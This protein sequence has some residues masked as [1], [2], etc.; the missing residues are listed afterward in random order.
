MVTRPPAGLADRVFDAAVV[1]ILALIGLAAL[2]PL[3]L[4]ISVS[5]TPYGEVLRRGGVVLIPREI[6]FE[7]YRQLWNYPRIFTAFKV[8]VFI[9][10]VGTLLNL[11]VSTPAA[12]ALSKEELPGRR[13]LFPIIVFTMYFYAG[14]I[15]RY[16]IVKTTGLLN[17]LWAMIVPGLISTFNMLI[18]MGYFRSLPVELFEAARLDGAGEFWILWA[19]AVPLAKPA[20]AVVGLLF[21][22]QQWNTFQRAIFFIPNRD[23]WPLQPVVREILLLTKLVIPDPTVSV[24]TVTM[25]M[26][27]VVFVSVPILSAYPFVQRY[28]TRGL[29][30]G[31]IKG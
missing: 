4:V 31:A 30:V 7:A 8:T 9:T 21:A 14:I 18:V 27:T 17:S 5:L 26:A 29:L 16:W 3:L 13:L 12:Y 10:L 2:L 6:T 1:F 15:P 11:L 19:V 23:L 22:V 24:P 25:Q 20:L 28:F